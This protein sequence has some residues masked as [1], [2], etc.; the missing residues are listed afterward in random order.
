MKLQFNAAEVA[1]L[2][3]QALSQQIALGQITGAV[4][5]SNGATVY[6][7]EEPDFEEIEVEDEDTEEVEDTPEVSATPKKRRR[8]RTKAQMQAASGNKGIFASSY[9]QAYA[10]FRKQTGES[11]TFNTLANANKVAENANLMSLYS[12][13]NTSKQIGRYD[14]SMQQ[15]MQVLKEKMR[16]QTYKSGAKE[17]RALDTDYKGDEYNSLTYF[18]G[19]N[20]SLYKYHDEE[21]KADLSYLMRSRNSKIAIDK[22]KVSN[23]KENNMKLTQSEL[24]PRNRGFTDTHLYS[25]YKTPR[26][27]IQKR[28]Q[29]IEYLQ[30]ATLNETMQTSPIGHHRM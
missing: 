8:R 22:F 24:N 2:L 19:S 28:N 20:P 4:V 16:A 23:L 27:K 26:A 29:D 13:M 25:L 7:N 14:S 11:V 12:I 18:S 3:C 17:F 15:E 10:D 5:T 30:Q 21:V 9:W 6:V 1:E